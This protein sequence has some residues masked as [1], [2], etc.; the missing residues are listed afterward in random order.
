MTASS[1]FLI[2]V[3]TQKAWQDRCRATKFCY[4]CGGLLDKKHAP[5]SDEHIIPK[6]VLNHFRLPGMHGW[7]AT[8]HVH[9]QCEEEHKRDADTFLNLFGRVSAADDGPPTRADALALTK[10]ISV[11][12]LPG[13]GGPT[14]LIAGVADT[15]VAVNRWV[16]GLFC[17]L[18]GEYLPLPPARVLFAAVPGL[19]TDAPVPIAEQL[20]DWRAGH[21]AI[22]FELQTADRERRLCRASIPEHGFSFKCCFSRNGSQILFLWELAVPLLVQQAQGIIGLAFPWRGFFPVASIPSCFQALPA[23][24]GAQIVSEGR[25]A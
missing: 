13:A 8:I 19:F 12:M 5:S 15:Y 9:K 11:E 24:S 3:S 18:F 16:Q 7:K 4:M 6:S 17:V 25:N 1:G 21:D 10:T 2:D 22:A 14:P 20:A 23:P